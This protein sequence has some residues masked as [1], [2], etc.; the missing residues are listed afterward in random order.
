[1]P[2]IRN[3]LAQY[4]CRG[5]PDLKSYYPEWVKNVADDATLEGT[6]LDGVIVG[7]E[8]LQS[9]VLKIKELYD[10]QD[11]VSVGPYG[12]N[13]WIEEYVAEIHGKPLGCILLVKFNDSG[14]AHHIVASY[15]PRTTVNYFANLL[16]D[17]F[18][19]TPIE[20]HFRSSES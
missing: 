17:E 20:E 6:M 5:D 11:F 13:D 10:R 19:G 4:S 18:A 15:R 9:V 7:R 8:G 12:D 16:A 1:M 2:I 3:K 14:Q